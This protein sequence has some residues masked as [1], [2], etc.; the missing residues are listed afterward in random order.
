MGRAWTAAER[1]SAG[2]TRDPT[3][4]SDMAD[5]RPGP[6]RLAWQQ[7]ARPPRRRPKGSALLRMLHTTDPKDIAILYL[8]TSFGF[9]LAGGA[10]ALLMRGELAVP[11]QQFLSNEQYNQL[12]TMHGTVMLL[13]LRDARPLR[14]R[15][16]HRAAADRRAG[17]GVPAAQ[18]LLLLA[19]PLRRDS[20]AMLGLP[21]ARAARPTS[22]GS[23]TPRCRTPSTPPA[24]VPTC[25]SMGLVVSA[26]WARSWARSTSSRRSSACAPPA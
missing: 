17:R 10:M 24:P 25:G 22:A 3:R 1:V 14:L 15:E 13:L 6:A 5:Q 20:S 2:G 21:H 7:V 9:F 11:G 18:R 16:L 12:F 19:V 4:R 8:V 26:A 23:P